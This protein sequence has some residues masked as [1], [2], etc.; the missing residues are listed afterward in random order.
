VERRRRTAA[1]VPLGLAG[2]GAEA[3]AT[4]G[5]LV[6]AVGVALLAV[7]IAMLV[8]RVVRGRAELRRLYAQAVTDVDWLIDDAVGSAAVA[9]REAHTRDVRQ[10]GDRIHDTLSTL[11]AAGGPEVAAAAVELRTQ[12]ND[13]ARTI[14]ARLGDPTADNRDL[15]VQ[16]GEKR[17]RIRRAKDDLAD[18]LR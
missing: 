6:A 15:E 10:R 8:A 3:G 1:L 5:G 9:D 14:V 13:L 16:V 18:R 2:C 11:A 7:A 12:A 17:E 4:T